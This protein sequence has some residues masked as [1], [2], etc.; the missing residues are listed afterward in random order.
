MGAVRALVTA[1]TEISLRRYR[2]QLTEMLFLI[3]H[4]SCLLLIGEFYAT[5]I[6]LTVCLQGPI[7][8]SWFD[9][10]SMDVVTYWSVRQR[11]SS[12]HNYG[13]STW[14]NVVVCHH[15]PRL[16]HPRPH[17]HPQQL[18]HQPPRRD[19]RLAPC[20]LRCAPMTTSLDTS[21]TN[22]DHGQRTALL[23]CPVSL[24]IVVDDNHHGGDHEYDKLQSVASTS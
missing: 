1:S 7:A 9:S 6:C 23:A 13:R 14:F 22:T 8:R 15:L 11:R 24:V 3:L 10:V 5:P 19:S 17:C 18:D 12:N 16:R 4:P 20:C 21:P 2:N